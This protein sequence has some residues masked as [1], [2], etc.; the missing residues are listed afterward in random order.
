MGCNVGDG[1]GRNDDRGLSQRAA[2]LLLASLLGW[3]GGCASDDAVKAASKPTVTVT[4]AVRPPVPPTPPQS[5]APSPNQPPVAFTG[6]VQGKAWQHTPASA[7]R[8]LEEATVALPSQASAIGRV[9]FGKLRTLSRQGAPRKVPVV[10]IMHGGLSLGPQPRQSDGRA[11]EE[12]Q[13]W[14]A[15]IGVASMAPDSSVLNDR[16]TYRSPAAKTAMEQVHALRSSELEYT[17]SKLRE[18]PWVDPDRVV[19]AGFGEGAVAVARYGGAGV[20]GRM[21]FG[22]SCESNY[23]VNAHRTAMLPEVPFLNVISGSDPFFSTAN[24]N[25]GASQPTG[26]CA[27]ALAGHRKATFVLIAGAPHTVANLPAARHAAQGF[28]IEHL[29]LDWR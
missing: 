16:I 19:V 9:A 29:Q 21:V 26:Y 24:A 11:V 27:G 4:P 13:R 5:P 15:T 25:L 3:L 6:E 23:F 12:W 20:R 22:W 2:A 17:L 14:L 8:L 10:V 1:L 18:L 28:L 7:Q